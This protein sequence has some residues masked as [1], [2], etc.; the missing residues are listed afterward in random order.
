[1]WISRMLE[2]RIQ[3]LV[4]TRPVVLVTGA[5]QTGKTS[6]LQHL[7]PDFG[8]VSLDLLSEAEQAANGPSAFLNRLRLRS[9]SMRF[10]TLPLY[11]GF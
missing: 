1:M 2:G 9:L 3:Q 11:S 4:A 8:F 5:R 10:S 6:I 7:F